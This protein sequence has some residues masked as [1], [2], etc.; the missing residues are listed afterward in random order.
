MNKKSWEAVAQKLEEFSSSTPCDDNKLPLLDESQRASLKE[1]AKRI[2]DGRRMVLIADEVGMGK[3]RI[4][5]AL[6]NAVQNAGGRTVVVLPAGLGAQW[7]KEIRYFNPYDKTLLPLRSYES[8]IAGFATKED[9]ADRSK[10]RKNSL[11]DRKLQRELPLESW[12]KEEVL[13]ISHNFGRMRFPKA[14]KN[15]QGTEAWR[16]ILMRLIR[17]F[18]GRENLKNPVVKNTWLHKASVSAARLIVSQLEEN[19]KIEIKSKTN[20][21][22][23]N[24]S[25]D[26][27]QSNLL[28]FIGKAL[29]RFDLIVID[30]AHKSRGEDSSLSKILEQMICKSSSAFCMGMT[31]TP[32]ELKS[33]QWVDTLERI[34]IS[35]EKLAGDGGLRNKID[36]YVKVV[37][38]VQ[39]EVLVEPLVSEFKKKANDF[40]NALRPYVIRRD[41]RD[42][43]DFAKYINCYRQVKP[44]PVTPDANNQ[45]IFP[46]HWLRLLAATEALSLLPDSSM[47]VKLQ[48]IQLAKGLGLNND[49]KL[50]DLN[51][52]ELESQSN[53]IDLKQNTDTTVND[54]PLNF[55]LESAQPNADVN[56][57]SH[58]AVL[59]AVDL[60]EIYTNNK[61]KV[62]VFGIFIEPLK[63]LTRLLDARAMLRALAADQYWPL[64]KVAEDNEA[65]VCAALKQID[66]SDKFSNLTDIN[67]ILLKTYPKKETERKK[68]LDK[69]SIDLK[70]SNDDAARFISERWRNS[71]EESPEKTEISAL[72][73]ALEERLGGAPE[74]GWT[75]SLFLTKFNELLDDLRHEGHEKASDKDEAKTQ[76]R[77][78]TFLEDYSGRDGSF[79]RLMRGTTSP[80]T[81]RNLQ[82]IFNRSNSRLMVLAAQSQVGREGLNLH[83][84]CKTV[85]MLHLEWNPAV[86]EQQIGR[87][88][89]KNSLWLK[90]LAEWEANGKVGEMPTI[91]IHP[92]VF[93]GTYGEHNWHK[94]EQRWRALRAQLHGDILLGKAGELDDEQKE[95]ARQIKEATPRF[96]P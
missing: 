28:P 80:D 61:Q 81:R 50:M 49:Q 8:F 3:T 22:Y 33:D 4:A 77:L 45:Q 51:E 64:S 1:L 71:S 7:Q 63:A 73:S 55:W 13:M 9:L 19:E 10:S 57:F 87:V 42:D 18:C 75:A 91:N 35:G 66:A 41:K 2:K 54:S 65:A 34:N 94:L 90:E 58:P 36:D 11:N 69:L 92:I 31:A 30:E 21:Y 56:V 53:P 93:S 37:Q 48:R 89:R 39:T 62:L 95:F 23:K 79:A 83:E 78:K 60:I 43:K 74:N 29:G 24:L 40:E 86:V 38:R 52:V 16:R 67:Q 17:I 59:A 15:E 68:Q 5:A 25:A 88:D 96:N 27:Y 82:A 44:F 84:A 76:T 26:E 85:V 12:V 46:M 32:V 20:N 72:L 47:K 6:I 70:E 14:E